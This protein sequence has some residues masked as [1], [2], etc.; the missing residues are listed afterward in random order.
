MRLLT[1]ASLTVAEGGPTFCW[2]DF[3]VT[4]SR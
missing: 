2:T 3:V 1:S 4:E